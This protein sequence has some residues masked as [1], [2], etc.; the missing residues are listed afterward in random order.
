MFIHKIFVVIF[1]PSPV[2]QDAVNQRYPEMAPEPDSYARPNEPW[3]SRSPGSPRSRARGCMS[4]SC[5]TGVARRY[6]PRRRYRA[7]GHQTGRVERQGR[8]IAD[9]VSSSRKILEGAKGFPHV[10][11]LLAL[12][13]VKFGR[14]VL[15]GAAVTAT[16]RSLGRVVLSG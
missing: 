7:P 12:H 1:M 6:R 8:S 16:C 4:G 2:I 5:S 14:H 10:D 15:R 9:A 3:C 11:R 13:C